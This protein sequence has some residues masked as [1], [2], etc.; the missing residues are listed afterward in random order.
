MTKKQEA[1]GNIKKHEV[2]GGP[3]AR[4]RLTA[5]TTGRLKEETWGA[6]GGKGL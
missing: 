1:G 6:L 4:R 5:A 2:L 3:G